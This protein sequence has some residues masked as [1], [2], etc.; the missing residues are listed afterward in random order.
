[1]VQRRPTI[2]DVA[3]LAGVSIK[4]VSRVVNREP[5]V[6]ESTRDKVDRAIAELGYRPNPSAQNLAS[7]RARLIV[8]VYDDPAAYEVPSSGYIINLQEGVLDACRERGFELVIHPCNYRDKSVSRDLRELISQARPSGI[9][10]AP[11]LS[12]MQKIVHVV[13][14]SDTPFVRI[15]AGSIHKGEFS[16]GTNDR[17]ICAEM[18][19]HLASTGHRLIAF[20]MGNRQHRA[21]RER[22]AGYKEGLERAGLEF[23][24]T[25]VAEGD[26]SIGSGE[27]CAL[28]LLRANPRPT[29]I[30]AANDDMAAGVIRIAM[31]LG[32]RVPEDLSVAGFDDISLARQ[33][34]PSLTTIRQPL[35]E[36]AHAASQA[37]IDLSRGHPHAPG[38]DIIP[39][40]IR[41]RESTGPAPS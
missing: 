5:N 25:L 32:I 15:S 7:S 24:E 3:A 41:L 11:P 2:E 17:E 21:V 23:S 26:N 33:I 14:E 1:M 16:V 22:F 9:V 36:M 4:T 34:F 29:A 19:E 13:N 37:L 31:Q 28:R 8:L 6:R 39:A 18:T 30:F 12:N 10:V 35:R 40:A 27:E 20:I 38:L